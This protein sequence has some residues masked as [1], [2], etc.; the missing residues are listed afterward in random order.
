MT[1]EEI[2]N[3]YVHGLHDA[4]TDNQEKIDMAKDIEEYAKR[5]A[6]SYGIFSVNFCFKNFNDELFQNGMTDDKLWDEYVKSK[7]KE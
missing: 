3:K 1:P 2:A 6:I 7:N 5:E 4:L